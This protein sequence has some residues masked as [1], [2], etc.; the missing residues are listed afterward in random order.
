MIHSEAIKGR[1]LFIP[2][3]PYFYY[4][5]L[6]C[7]DQPHFPFKKKVCKWLTKVHKVELLMWGDN[8]VSM[9][10]HQL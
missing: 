9:K 1:K 3:L 8:D 7:L 10:F 6:S 2:R 5:F 4:F